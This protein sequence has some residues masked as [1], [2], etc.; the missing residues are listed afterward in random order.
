MRCTLEQS[1]VIKAVIRP[2]PRA[3][4]LRLSFGNLLRACTMC[5]LVI[6]A[7]ATGRAQNPD[8]AVTARRVV[9]GTGRLLPG[10]TVVVR[11]GR[12]VSV[13]ARPAGFRGT[14]Y[15]LGDATLMPGLIDVHSH[16]VWYF[17]AKGRFHTSD[18]GESPVQSMLAA[19]GN[20]YQTLMSGVTTLQSP[21]SPEDGDLRDAIMRGAIPGPRILTSLGSL[22]ERSG[23]PDELRQKVRDLKARG[24]NLLKLF[25][26]RSIREG[27][28]QTMSDA[29]L[30]AACGEAKAIS[31]RT[32]VHAH[33][34]EAMK[35]AV[36]A[37]C[38]QIEHGVFATP[39]VLSLMV[40]R[41]TFLSPQCGLVF[42]NYLDN[43]VKY[44]GI[45]NY[46]DEGFAAME[47]SLP[48][49]IAAVR[50]AVHTK[51]LKVV[52]GTD[53]VAGAH[54]RN[55][56]DLI[57]RVTEAGQDPMAALVSATGL[58][59]Q[60]LGLA[61]SIGTL[62]GGKLADIIAV[63]GDPLAEITIMRRVRFVMKGGHVYR[64]DAVPAQERR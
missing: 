20:A 9:D 4:T 13:G 24:A 38:D 22:S 59:A 8:V 52:F 41:G 49:A 45:G 35:A 47:R 56:E 5:A 15:D 18:D 58:A 39:E 42:R 25:A 19:A 23:T 30:V 62:A 6:V 36:M 27:G 14:T 21:G 2:D 63:D 37:G 10:A 7:P 40:E 50:R 46:N 44:A 55:V 33:S 1:A 61:D 48:I 34:A 28:A 43:R 11:D 32:L 53:A 17:N 60:S 16:V 51:G 31:L 26:S 57:C 3:H 64:N 54:G 12:I 29:Q